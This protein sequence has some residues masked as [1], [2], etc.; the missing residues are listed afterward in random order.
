[1]INLLVIFHSKQCDIILQ[2]NRSTIN[3]FWKFHIFCGMCE[4]QTTTTGLFFFSIKK[5]VELCCFIRDFFSSA[6]LSFQ[7]EMAPRGNAPH[8]ITPYNNVPLCTQ[9]F[10]IRRNEKSA[11]YH[12]HLLLWCMYNLRRLNCSDVQWKPSIRT[13]TRTYWPQKLRQLAGTDRRNW[14]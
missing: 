5:I 13:I 9:F 7:Y 14:Y 1:M 3:F 4:R 12:A 11:T 8:S 6:I 2:H 10:F